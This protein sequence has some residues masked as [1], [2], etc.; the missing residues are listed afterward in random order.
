MAFDAAALLNQ[1]QSEAHSTQVEACPPGEYQS[2]I[3][4]VDIKDFQ[5]RQ[6]DR[7]GQTGY[8][9]EVVHLIVDPQVEAQLGRQPVVRQSILLD[10][11]PT[12]GLD[13]SKGKNVGLGR[14]REA[15]GQ[16]RAGMAWSPKMLEGQQLVVSVEHR[17][18]GDN[19][20]ADVK[21]VRKAS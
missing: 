3:Q 11:T 6:G 4:S 15:V 1:T 20:F 16:N 12:G 17:M 14:L 5:Y 18:D 19:V 7:A 21:K 9:L 13:T 10:V 2:V 8:R